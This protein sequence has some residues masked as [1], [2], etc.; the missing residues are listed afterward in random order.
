MLKQM[1]KSEYALRRHLEAPLL[2]EREEYLSH[3]SQKHLNTHRMMM[4]ENCI[5][6]II[7]YF[8]LKDSD[9]SKITLEELER[10]RAKWLKSRP[11][12]NGSDKSYRIARA[13]FT[14]I[15]TS[16]LTWIGRLDGRYNDPQNIFNV[17]F[18]CSFF[19]CRFFTA[20]MYQERESYLRYL[21][22]TGMCTAVVRVNATFQLHVIEYLRLNRPRKVSLEEI[23]KAAASWDRTSSKSTGKKRGNK[24][25]KNQFLWTAKTW[26]SFCG[27]YSPAENNPSQYIF[28]ESYLKWLMEECGYSTYTYDIRKVHLK[29]FFEY[30]K[31]QSVNLDS[32]ST[33]DIDA[34][35]EREK[36][37][38]LS[39]ASIAGLIATLRNFVDYAAQ[40]GWCKQGLKDTILTTRTYKQETPPAYVTWD[41]V[42]QVI[43]TQDQETA[44]GIRNR[45]ALLLMATYGLREYEV[46]NLKIRDIDWRNEKL[47]IKRAKSGRE[48]Y[49]PLVREVGDAIIKYLKEG[50]YNQTLDDHLFI[51]TRAPY[52]KLNNSGLYW[53]VSAALKKVGATPLKYG[54]HTL[55]HSC[56]THLV[57]SGHTLK[58]VADLLGHQGLDTTRVY[59][60]VNLTALRNV[61]DMSW[62]VGL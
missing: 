34:F 24:D 18:T 43:D 51:T 28:A 40:Q 20:P 22:S 31:Q 62:E 32:L 1:Y 11:R 6:F 46:L 56:A 5:L 58:E 35:I 45:A 27:C 12:S 42:K 37:R 39:R 59:A 60:K 8:N 13:K 19:R 50:R 29:S 54:P 48:Q 30:L 49:L 4:Y 21:V 52:N 57:N 44:V 53:C 41:V 16:W 25:S 9:T 3:L 10:C 26:L 47:H 2:R 14:Q 38:N 15:S 55:R 7:N 33:S 17:I 23:E 36:S 61:A